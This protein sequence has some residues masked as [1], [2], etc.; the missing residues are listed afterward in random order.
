[1]VSGRWFDEMHMRHDLLTHGLKILESRRLTTSHQHNPWFALDNGAATEH[2]GEVWFG[3]LEWSGNWKLSAEVTEYQATRVSL[4]INDW[5]FEWRLNPGETFT[6]PS[7]FA[8]YSSEGFGG[9]SRQLHDF[10]RDSVLPHKHDTHKVL[11]NSWEATFFDVDETSQAHLAE[12]A[13]AMGVELFVVDDGWFHGRVTDNAGLG[14]WWPDEHKFPNGLTPLIERV[15]ALGMDFGI[16]VEP[17]MVNPNSDLY[18]AHPDWVL[19]FPSRARTE[20][21]NQLVLNLG[22]TDVQDYLIASLD[23]LLSDHNIAFVKW[24]MNRNVSEPGW[25][26][27]TGEPREMWV[28][29]VQGLYRLFAT[30]REKH[31]HVVFQSCSGGG[32][33]ADLGMLRFADQIWVSDNTEA[34]AR[35]SIQYGFSHIYPANTMEAWVTDVNPDNLSLQFRFHVSMSGV[36]GVGGHL[37]HWSESE[38]AEAA[39][40]IALYKEIRPTIQ[41]GDQYRLSSP[42]KQSYSSVLYVSKDKSEGVLF[43][44]RLHLPPPAHLPV[45]KLVGLDPEALY[46]IEG[47][48]EPRSGSAWMHEGLQINLKNFESA[49]RHIKRV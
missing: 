42:Q 25:P 5:D 27:A 41:L 12:L 2:R 22:R 10:I 29:Y 31:P 21:R 44:Y 34:S 14:D 32:G 11:Y 17:E 16:W 13:S 38:R 39:Q 24:D 19:H 47:I 15:N 8:G 49:L 43:A 28:R 30:L 48:D 35:L 23:K 36:L 37:S 33:R 45:I 3:L 9:A 46:T 20:A 7:S 18:R 6:T 40:L 4:G 26:D 1:H